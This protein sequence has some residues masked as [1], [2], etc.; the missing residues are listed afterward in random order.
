RNPQNT[1]LTHLF[2]AL[3][4]VLMMRFSRFDLV[5]FPYWEPLAVSMGRIIGRSRILA[6]AFCEKSH[7][8]RLT[9]H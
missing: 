4:N 5:A 1:L 6:R 3:F 8:N 7:K 9:V 2:T